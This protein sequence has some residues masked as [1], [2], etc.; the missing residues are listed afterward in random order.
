MSSRSKHYLLFSK[1]RRYPKKINEGVRSSCR[2]LF[3]SNCNCQS[4]EPTKIFN[5]V[6]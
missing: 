5:D 1:I 3:V 4:Q 6:K 2:F